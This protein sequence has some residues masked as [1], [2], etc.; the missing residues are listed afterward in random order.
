MHCFVSGRVQGVFYRRF[1]YDKAKILGLSGWARN[2]ADGRVEVL[3]CGKR[4]SVEN[5]VRALWVGP[6]AAHVTDV[7]SQEIPFEQHDGFTF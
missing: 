3:V 4:E 5:L 7:Q 1:V 6:P 2:L